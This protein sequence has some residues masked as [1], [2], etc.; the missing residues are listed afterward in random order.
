MRYEHLAPT[1]I[2]SDH[3]FQISLLEAKVNTSTHVEQYV[4]L[5]TNITE[6]GIQENYNNGVNTQIY[7]GASISVNPD[8]GVSDSALQHPT[9]VW[10]TSWPQTTQRRQIYLFGW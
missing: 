3:S 6:V 4:A 1:P 2:V 8:L 10:N 7:C 5:P 9:S